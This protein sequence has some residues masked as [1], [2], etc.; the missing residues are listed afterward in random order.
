M[1]WRWRFYKEKKETLYILIHFCQELEFYFINRLT[2][3]RRKR[4]LFLFKLKYF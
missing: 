2:F 4:L 3:G 1:L